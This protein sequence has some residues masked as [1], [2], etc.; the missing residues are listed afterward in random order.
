MAVRVLPS[1]ADV[2]PSLRH[3][4]GTQPPVAVPQ[5]LPSLPPPYSQKLG[6]SL[7]NKL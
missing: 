4:Q 6:L 3:G 2:A 7:P 5:P 1:A